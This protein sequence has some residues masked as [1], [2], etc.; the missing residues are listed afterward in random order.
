M[1]NGNVHHPAYPSMKAGQ[2][3]VGT[4]FMRGVDVDVGIVGMNPS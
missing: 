1:M 2:W 4:G 3:D